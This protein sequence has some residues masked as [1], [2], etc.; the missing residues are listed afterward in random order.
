M[1]RM[2]CSITDGPQYD[3]DEMFSS[4]P[5][6]NP[7]DQYDDWVFKKMMSDLEPLLT[8]TRLSDKEIIEMYDEFPDLFLHEIALMAGKSV[9]E[10]KEILRREQK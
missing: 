1:N 7:D 2:P 5:E 4:K 6:P 8:I 10:L 3:D 9:P